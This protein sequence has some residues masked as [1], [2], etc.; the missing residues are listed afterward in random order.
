MQK[1]TSAGKEIQR[2]ML[3]EKDGTVDNLINEFT[4]EMKPHANHTFIADWQRKQ[5]RNITQSIPNGWFVSVVDFAQNYRCLNRDEI[6]SAHY[7]YQQATLFI[8]VSYFECPSFE[9]GTVQESAVFISPDLKHDTNAVN[10]VNKLMNEHIKEKVN[11]DIVFILVMDV[12]PN[13][14][15][16]Q[17]GQDGPGSLTSFF[18]IALAIFF[19]FFCRFQRNIYKNFLMS[20][21][22]KKPPF[23]NTMFIDR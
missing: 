14:N 22:C 16:K 5:F 18:E 7:N 2:Q 17:E 21:Q 13:S 3:I 20:V 19:F 12:Q 15:L 1:T 11:T 6:Q 8:L 4:E 9:N 23:T 10:H